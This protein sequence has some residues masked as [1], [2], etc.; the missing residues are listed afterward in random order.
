MTIDTDIIE[1]GR[2]L[3]ISADGKNQLV[4]TL[5]DIQ[6]ELGYNPKIKY[7][8]KPIHGN[9]IRNVLLKCGNFQ[10]VCKNYYTIK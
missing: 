7:S 3:S 8:E 10:R 5:R 9:K 2:R 4:F 6:R 1:A